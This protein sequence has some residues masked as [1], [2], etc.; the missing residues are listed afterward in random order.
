MANSRI[1]VPV[2][3][4]DCSGAALEFAAG[5]APTLNASL[6]IVHVWDRPLY[7]SESIQVGPAG[8]SRPLIDMI[9]EN[10]ESE[11]KNFLARV[12]LPAGVEVSHRVLSGSPARTVLDELGRGQY[13]LLVIGTNG[14]TGLPHLLLGSVAERLIRLSPVPVMTVPLA[15][16][17]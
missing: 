9:H 11:M 10:A 16:V 12:A 4:S 6:D 7:V 13:R 3:Y 1:L 8:N 14:R 17:K 15:G 5:L 2:D